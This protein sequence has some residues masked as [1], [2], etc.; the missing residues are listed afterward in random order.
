MRTNRMT[1]KASALLLVFERSLPATA[2]H[3]R[4]VAEAAMDIADGL[5]LDEDRRE[6]L[7][8]GALFHDVGKLNVPRGLLMKPG[9]LT[10]TERAL[11]EPHAEL[12]AQL[13]EQAG[14][15]GDVVRLVRTHHERLNGSGY[16]TRL[17]ADALSLEVRILA[18][19]DVYDAFTHDR[20]Y[21]T[22]RSRE[23]ALSYLRANAGSLFDLDVVCWLGRRTETTAPLLAA[24]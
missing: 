12:G 18:V 15:P 14:L 13:A 9:P 11:I 5:G 1:M 19:C 16:P 24:A 8:L 2:A 21:A 3:S 6:N 23:H 17:E 10:Q 22:A 20:P 4:R 7:R